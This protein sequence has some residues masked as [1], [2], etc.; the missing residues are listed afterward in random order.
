MTQQELGIYGEALAQDYL[1]QKDYLIIKCNYRFLKA[2]IDIICEKNEK[3]IVVEVKTRQT[4][5]IGEPWR[6][7]T[8]SKQKQIIKAANFYIQNH[9]VDLETQFD[10]ISIVHNSF[11]TEIEHIEDAFSA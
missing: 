2:E 11:R 4:A 1:K 7:V 10:I 5:E 3:L 8:R 6:A 9:N